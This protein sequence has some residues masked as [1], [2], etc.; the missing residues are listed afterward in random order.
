MVTVCI[1]GMLYLKIDFLVF[2]SLSLSNKNLSRRKNNITD[3]SLALNP[4]PSS[5]PVV[6][7]LASNRSARIDR[8]NLE[9]L[10]SVPRLC[11]HNRDCKF[12]G[13]L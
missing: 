11:G 10:N 3:N 13:L 4:R 7:R 1:K 2:P 5:G 6:Y 12:T 9:V 8:L